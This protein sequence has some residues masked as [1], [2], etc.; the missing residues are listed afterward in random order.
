MYK[1]VLLYQFPPTP[2]PFPPGIPPD[3]PFIPPNW[4]L[5]MFTDF[6]IQTWHW[7]D[8]ATTALQAIVLLGIVLFGVFKILALIKSFGGGSTSPSE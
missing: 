2:T 5:W 3:M 1:L 8:V 6:A 7:A 4:N